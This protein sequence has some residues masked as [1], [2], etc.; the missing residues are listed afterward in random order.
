MARKRHTLGQNIR[1]L[2]GSLRDR[3]NERIAA[4]RRGRDW[5]GRSGAVRG[6]C[7][8]PLQSRFLPPDP[9][10]TLR[11]NN[12]RIQQRPRALLGEASALQRIALMERRVLGDDRI[13]QYDAAYAKGGF[14]VFLG[15]APDGGIS[16]FEIEPR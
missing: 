11:V 1:M 8:A 4:T 3:A 10:R 14:R 7:R 16:I 5:P 15:L 9:V 6:K 13:F 2:R 12:S